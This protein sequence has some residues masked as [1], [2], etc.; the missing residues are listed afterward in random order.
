MR[1]GAALEA[2]RF[3]RYNFSG[4]IAK[5]K[6]ILRRFSFYFFPFFKKRKFQPRKGRSHNQYLLFDSSG[7]AMEAL[8]RGSGVSEYR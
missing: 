2:W 5:D 4:W 1:S 3:L 6:E 7:L 8:A